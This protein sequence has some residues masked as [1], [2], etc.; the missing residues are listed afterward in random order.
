MH[1]DGRDQ[2]YLKLHILARQDHFGPTQKLDLTGHVRRPE[3]E[4]RPIADEERG[5]APAFFLGQEYTSASNS[6]CGVM[7]PGCQDL[8]ALH[9]VLLD[10]AQQATDVVAAD[11]S[12]AS[13]WNIST[14]VTVVSAVSRRPTISTSSPTL[15]GR[16]S[17]RPVATVPRPSIEKTS[18]IAIR[19]G[20]SI[21]G[22][23][24]DVVVDGVQEL[25]MHLAPPGSSGFW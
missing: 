10:A 3:V 15:I 9:F 5:V 17:I 23:F 7:V 12:S 20:L 1:R 24:G 19:N 11:P 22:R 14:P 2:L 13:C 18:S 6:V 4:L 21:A 8:T 25:L 16:C